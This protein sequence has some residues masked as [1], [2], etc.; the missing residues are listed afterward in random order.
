MEKELKEISTEILEKAERMAF[1]WSVRSLSPKLA[2]ITQYCARAE[3]QVREALS[4]VDYSSPIRMADE[5][6]I[7]FLEEVAK[8]RDVLDRAISQAKYRDEYDLEV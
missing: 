2:D 4:K 6:T 1:E 3:Q 8:D 7:Q 5:G